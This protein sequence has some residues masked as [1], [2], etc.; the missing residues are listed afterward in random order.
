MREIQITVKL[1]DEFSSLEQLETV[2]HQ[3]GQQIKQHLFENELQA[4]IDQH[5]P[6]ADEPVACPH[7]QKKTQLA[8]APN[9][10]N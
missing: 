8:K 5:P 6:T 4:I 10:D 1:P 9:R 7:C 2:I 3:E